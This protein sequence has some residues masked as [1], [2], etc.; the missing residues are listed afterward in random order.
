MPFSKCDYIK[1]ECIHLTAPRDNAMIRILQAI[2]ASPV[3]IG[4]GLVSRP[5]QLHRP[6]QPLFRD[7]WRS[8]PARPSVRRASVGD[9]VSSSSL[10]AANTKKEEEEEEEEGDFHETREK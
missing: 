3:C 1:L 4:P 9:C 7:A 2:N 6:S 5:P 8:L 10:H